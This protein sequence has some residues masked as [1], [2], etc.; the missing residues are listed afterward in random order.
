MRQGRDPVLDRAIAIRGGL[1]PLAGALGVTKQAV[2]QWNRCPLLR[3][4]PLSKATGIPRHEIRP[5]VFPPPE[6]EEKERG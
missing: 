1:G 4:I 5:D 2:S 6:A 3:V